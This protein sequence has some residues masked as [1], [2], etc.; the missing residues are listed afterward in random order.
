MNN[1]FLNKNIKLLR[2]MDDFIYS[3]RTDYKYLTDLVFL[4]NIYDADN[5]TKKKYLNIFMNVF[6]Y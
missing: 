4:G 5:I 1:K 6:I 3:N 2:N